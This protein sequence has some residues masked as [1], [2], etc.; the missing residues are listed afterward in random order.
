[1]LAALR[2]LTI[3]PVPGEHRA[4]TPASVA[5]FPVVGLVVGVVWALAASTTNLFLNT[6]VA[7]ALV[8]VADALVTGGLHLDGLADATDGVASRRRG[9]AGVA[10]MRDPSVGAAGA[11][12]VALALLVRHSAL[13][14]LSGAPGIALALV[15]VPIMGRVAMVV[16][17]ALVPARTDGSLTASV[18]SPPRWAVVVAVAGGALGVGLL[19]PRGL[20]G[21]GVAAVI[22]GAVAVGWRR[23][24]G[25]L[26]GDAVGACCVLAE[27]GALLTLAATLHSP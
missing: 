4:P 22:A 17:L 27:T 9:D 23:R 6:G 25:A 12:A 20:A 15:C 7:A 10:V 18:G 21:L 16:L 13:L 3:L 8:L 24:F 5:A 26:A 2:L 19:D 1:M 14:G 11:L